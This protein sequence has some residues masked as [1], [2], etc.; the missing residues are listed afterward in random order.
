MEARLQRFVDELIESE[1][2]DE[3]EG[4]WRFPDGSVCSIC[5]SAAMLVAHEFRGAVFGYWGNENPTARIGPPLS[6]GHDFALV[7]ARWIVDYW[8]FRVSQASPRCVLDLR[9][10]CDRT[11]AQELYGRQDLWV[12]VA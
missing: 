5:I 8:A 2:Y 11:L 1:S 12:R 6:E 7:G 10:R 9:S 3:S 4:V